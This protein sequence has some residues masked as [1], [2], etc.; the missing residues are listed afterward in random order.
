MCNLSLFVIII[1]YYNCKLVDVSNIIIKHLLWQSITV[2]ICVWHWNEFRSN[3]FNIKTNS[4]TNK[5]V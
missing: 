1:R 2:D 5:S 4:T 3:L